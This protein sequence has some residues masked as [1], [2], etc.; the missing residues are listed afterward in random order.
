MSDDD[1]DDDDEDSG[2]LRSE[3]ERWGNLSCSFLTVP[4]GFVVVASNAS[5]EAYVRCNPGHRLVGGSGWIDCENVRRRPKCLRVNCPTP[6]P[7]ENGR[8][9]GVNGRR[10]F[11]FGDVVA[12]K[13]RARF[14]VSRDRSFLPSQLLFSTLV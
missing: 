10:E 13:V 11:F 4:N 5:S 9:V 1:D 12:Y 14:H 6:E 3:F 2:A 8:F 7:P